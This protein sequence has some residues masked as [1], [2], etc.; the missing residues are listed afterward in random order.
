MSRA[1]AWRVRL[2]LIL[3]IAVFGLLAVF[4]WVS[5]VAEPL[6]VAHLPDFHLPSDK[7]LAGRDKSL[8]S[9]PASERPLFWP[10]RRPP[11]EV[12]ETAQAMAA[13]ADGIQL[14]GIVVQGGVRMALLGTKEGV[15]RVRAADQV[16]GWK[17]DQIRPEGVRLLSG[18]QKVE[19]L[20]T[21][22]RREGIRIEPAEPV[23]P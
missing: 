6:R 10:S 23:A 9:G 17:V 11:S 4:L 16:M 7:M 2:G 21:P 1:L 8:V 3:G 13:S 20:V 5:T 14:L 19:L 12:A 22:Q 15:K 18:Q